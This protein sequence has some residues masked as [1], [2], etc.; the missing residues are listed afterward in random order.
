MD[1]LKICFKVVINL[2]PNKNRKTDW[3]IFDTFLLDRFHNEWIS[4]NL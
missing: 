4:Q 1:I 3:R 2:I